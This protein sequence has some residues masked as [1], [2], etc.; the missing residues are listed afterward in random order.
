MGQWLGHWDASYLEVAVV[1]SLYTVAA[2][3]MWHHDPFVKI[4]KLIKYTAIIP[5]VEHELHV[6]V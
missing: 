5:S 1:F 6:H 3:S 4:C 2:T